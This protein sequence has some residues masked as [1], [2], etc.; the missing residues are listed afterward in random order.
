MFIVCF[1]PQR[2]IVGVMGFFGIVVAY[3]MRICLSTVLT[4]LVKQIQ[5]TKNLT[6]TDVCP[7]TLEP[8]KEGGGIY[9]WDQFLQ[10]F[11]IL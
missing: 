8:P 7:G 11:T 2:W 9:D 3:L 10:V 4:Q 5:D 6:H 1:V